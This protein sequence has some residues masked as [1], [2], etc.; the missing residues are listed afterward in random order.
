MTGSSE[1]DRVALM[2]IVAARE[3]EGIAAGDG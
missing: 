3:R 2:Q 1:T